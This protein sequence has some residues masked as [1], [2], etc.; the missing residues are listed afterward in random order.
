MT[1]PCTC[2]A[3]LD[4]AAAERNTRIGKTIRFGTKPGEASVLPTIVTE[5]VDRTKRGR[6]VAILPTFC[7]FCG[8]RLI[9]ERTPALPEGEAA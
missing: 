9:L 5:K 8:V 6:T 4:T 3:E 2:I 1:E 7:P